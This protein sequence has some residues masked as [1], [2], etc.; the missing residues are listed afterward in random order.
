MSERPNVLFIPV[1]DLRT[2]LGCYGCDR[3]IS[4]NMDALARDGIV[5]E[6][7]YC[8][9]AISAPSRASVLSGCRPD[10]TGIYGLK[11]PLRDVMPNVLT[12]P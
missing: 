5:F 6:N 7:A 12:L 2:E 10:T 3:V 11:T 1:D 9:Q 8:Q 4:P